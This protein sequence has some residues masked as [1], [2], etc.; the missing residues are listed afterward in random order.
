MKGVA[1]GHRRVEDLSLDILVAR[2]EIGRRER[3]SVGVIPEPELDLMQRVLPAGDIEA[4][5]KK[6][7][8]RVTSRPPVDQAVHDRPSRPSVPNFR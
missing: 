6:I 8:A 1:L 4:D 5:Q 2:Q 3:E 7:T